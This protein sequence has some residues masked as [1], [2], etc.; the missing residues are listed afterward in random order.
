M[1][2]TRRYDSAL[3]SHFSFQPRTES[4]KCPARAVIAMSRARHVHVMSL[5][6]LT[7]RKVH[8]FNLGQPMNRYFRKQKRFRLLSIC[9]N[10]VYNVIQ[11]F[12]DISSI[13][14]F[15][16]DIH[17]AL[18]YVD[19]FLELKKWRNS[20]W[21]HISLSPSLSLY[22]SICRCTLIFPKW[23][24]WHVPVSPSFSL[25][26]HLQKRLGSRSDPNGIQ[27]RMFRQFKN[28]CMR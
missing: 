12:K 6:L 24:A 18:K 23:C 20:K 9:A 16:K 8:L 2:K 26:L 14:I 19:E 3:S 28:L 10:A 11:S 1:L 13:R 25:Y 4:V 17:E 7:N 22:L 15:C 5:N 21:T 27:E